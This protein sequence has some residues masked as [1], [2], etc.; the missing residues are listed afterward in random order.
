LI[1]LWKHLTLSKR[2]ALKNLPLL[3]LEKISLATLLKGN[4]VFNK[5][6]NNKEFIML[7]IQKLKLASLLIKFVLVLI[8]LI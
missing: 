5:L 3:E 6:E 1:E 7:R 8:A 4:I 2:H